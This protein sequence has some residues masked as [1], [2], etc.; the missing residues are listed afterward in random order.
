MKA[1][2]QKDD[3]ASVT[4]PAR[5][6][7]GK[8]SAKPSPRVSEYAFEISVFKSTASKQIQCRKEGQ[9]HNKT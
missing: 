4:A 9:R 8:P 1:L 2:A 7:D 6:G 3:K 5:H